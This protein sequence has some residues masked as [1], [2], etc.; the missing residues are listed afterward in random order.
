MTIAINQNNAAN[1]S[2]G[3]PVRLRSDHCR[4]WWVLFR[5]AAASAAMIGQVELANA[6]GCEGPVK[7]L[8]VDAGGGVFVALDAP[9]QTPTHSI[10]N[11]TVQGSYTM[12]LPACKAAYASLL[13]AK[14]AN[15]SATIFYG[16]ASSCSA[17]PSWVPV[18]DAYHVSGPN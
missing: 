11:L 2:V 6:I 9:A 12:T 18:L 4:P 15:A 7:Y 8:G 5:A 10:C 16:Q 13:V 1:G 3:K 17:L 14:A